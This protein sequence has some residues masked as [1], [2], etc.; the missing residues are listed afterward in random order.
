MFAEP[1]LVDP[2]GIAN[3]LSQTGGH[4]TM[5]TSSGKILLPG[6]TLAGKL[7]LVFWMIGAPLL[8][9]TA[10]LLAADDPVIAGA[11]VCFGVPGMAGIW[12]VW[13]RTRLRG[14]AVAKAGQP[15]GLTFQRKLGKKDL[16]PLQALP[17]M[18]DNWRA[19]V[20]ENALLGELAGRKAIVM[21][22]HYFTPPSY[23]R[24]MCPT[25]IAIFLDGATGL[26]NFRLAPR[27]SLPGRIALGDKH[28]I[29]L[30]ND[31][32]LGSGEFAESYQVADGD[33]TAVRQF[34]SAAKQSFF[35]QDP[36]WWLIVHNG[37]LLFGGT[38]LI[39]PKEYPAF[40]SLVGQMLHVLHGP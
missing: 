36:N 6:W 5:P 38:G 27:R 33:P 31:L 34:L 13:Y 20:A 17:L 11:W 24:A 9:G 4:A 15:L 25:T 2:R 19:C 37:A 1:E 22:Y 40:L 21:D 10:F 30:F 35:A 14:L 26:P 32:N 16:E 8:I 28:P 23:E 3:G 18:V 12:A 7:W 29:F 39:S